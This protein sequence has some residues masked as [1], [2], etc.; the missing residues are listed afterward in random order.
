M[1]FREALSYGRQRESGDVSY[2]KN[3]TLLVFLRH[4]ISALHEL[5]SYVVNTKGLI[6]VL[7][8]EC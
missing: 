6:F 4:K 1:R 3:S 8:N 5:I 2:A 7:N